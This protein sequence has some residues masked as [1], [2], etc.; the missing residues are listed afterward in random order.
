M[1][2][3]IDYQKQQD[4]ILESIKNYEF[5]MNK[6]NGSNNE[7]NVTQL[8]KKPSLLLHACCA[9][10]SSYVIEALSNIFDITIY[11][12]NPNIHPETEYTR[13]LT[14]LQNFLQKFIPA[15]TN[16]V[17][18]IAAPYNP[19][20]FFIATNSR[21]EI[22]LQTENERGERCRRCYFLRMKKAYEFAKANSFDFF[23]T[24]LSISPYKDSKM[25]NEI[26]YEL[27]NSYSTIP[28]TSQKT[29][30]PA[31]K[32]IITKS[33]ISTRALEKISAQEIQS[34]SYRPST[35]LHYLPADFKKHNG[36]LRSLEI[37][38]EYGLYRQDYCG[39]IYSKKNMHHSS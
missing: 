20:D 14:E 1:N 26:G 32:N 6:T 31:A 37:S 23:T 21:K 9:P 34:I 29:L 10:C 38:K 16:K 15:L 5:S 28:G 30:V 33:N 27:E 24:T 35:G 12:Y 13:R 8:L 25:I 19:E 4:I 36:F 18:L 22:E 3:K 39:C 17:T 7:D 2:E 11:Y